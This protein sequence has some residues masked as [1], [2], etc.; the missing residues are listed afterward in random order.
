[1]HVLVTGG[2][3]YIG[4][5]ATRALLDAGHRVRVYDNLSTGHRQAVDPRAELVI[6][7]LRD[8][9]TLARALD[10]MDAVLHFAARSLVAESVREPLAYWNNNVGGS[11]SLL[12]T[13]TERGVRRLIFS[14]TAA[15][16]GIP[17][18]DPITEDCPQHPINPYGSSKLAV[19]RLIQDHAASQR[20]F[21]FASLR[22]FN[23]AGCAWGLGEDH[24][25][26]THLIPIV[27]QCAAG[28][29][30]AIAIFGTD[31]PTPDG[32]CIRDYVHVRDLVDAHVVVLEA[33]R[34]GDARVYNIGSGRG[35]SVREVI[36]A[37]KSVTGTDFTVKEAD[38]RPG[39]PATLVTDPSR[40]TA[41][42]GWRT[43]H[44]DL[45]VILADHW[46]WTQEHP[47]G[48]ST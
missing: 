11:L 46:A 21:S 33:L 30:D 2:A 1:M 27:L 32:T 23:V 31:Y 9:D 36:E 39:D 28:R 18:V 19:E 15:T 44:S 3:G 40:I 4:S 7:D 8:R 20:D 5:H 13:M 35:W 17:E 41:E 14:S 12:Q 24:H 34:P 6:G 48:W 47:G 43:R 10:G 16:Y 22:Y 38:R 29:R 45:R 25:P 26:E 37:A 42:L